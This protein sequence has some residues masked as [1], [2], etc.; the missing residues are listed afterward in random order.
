M[1]WG[2]VVTLITVLVALSSVLWAYRGERRA[3]RQEASSEAHAD[4][5]EQHADMSEQ[6]ADVA[7]ALAVKQ[8]TIDGFRDQNELLRSQFA[9]LKATGEKR[10]DAWREREKAWHIERIE[11]NKRVDALSS[12]VTDILKRSIGLGVCDNAGTC[13][14]Y[15]A[16]PAVKAKA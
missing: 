16:V 7:E 4:M 3:H 14:N 5:A 9:D 13:A 12:Q 11:L 2:D 8:A 15:R 6:H 10:E 1:S